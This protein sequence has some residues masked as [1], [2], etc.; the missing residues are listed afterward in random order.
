MGLDALTQ[1]E[2]LREIDRAGLEMGFEQAESPQPRLELLLAIV[3]LLSEL[4]E[5]DKSADV[6]GA[7]AGKAASAAAAGA[8]GACGGDRLK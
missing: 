8:A 4:Q 7:A 3:D 5:A 1:L 2:D 6:S